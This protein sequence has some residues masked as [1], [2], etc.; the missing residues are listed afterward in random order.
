MAIGRSMVS[1]TWYI[2]FCFEGLFGYQ[3]VLGLVLRRGADEERGTGAESDLA[4]LDSAIDCDGSLLDCKHTAD[5]EVPFM[6]SSTSV[7]GVVE[8]AG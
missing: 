4:S 8:F 5:T 2:F 6:G 3:L 7:R 1:S